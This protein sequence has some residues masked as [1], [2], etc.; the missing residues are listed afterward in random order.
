MLAIFLHLRGLL[1]LYGKFKRFSGLEKIFEKLVK[2]SKLEM[3]TLSC[4]FTKK[5]ESSG[6][7]SSRKRSYFENRRA[8]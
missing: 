8:S 2:K 6:F 3:E 1:H 5:V 4:F 7:L